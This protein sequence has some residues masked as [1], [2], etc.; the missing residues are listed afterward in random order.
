MNV[1]IP[2][3]ATQAA[4]AAVEDAKQTL[5]NTDMKVGDSLFDQV[6]K[7]IIAGVILSV[8]AVAVVLMVIWTLKSN[9]A[10][11]NYSCNTPPVSPA[12]TGT[13]CTNAWID[14][15][16]TLKDILSTAVIPLLTLVLGFYFGRQTATND[17]TD[18][19]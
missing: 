2:D 6:P 14:K 10:G 9:P 8:W 18:N 5:E 16:D 17:G 15:R 1:P 4:L 7:V 3:P 19:G 13:D 12:T 11:G